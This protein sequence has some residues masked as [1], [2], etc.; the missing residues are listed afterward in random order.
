[1]LDGVSGALAKTLSAGA[2]SALGAGLKEATR[3]LSASLL[4]GSF[5]SDLTP[6]A[7]GG[8][9]AVGT[10]TPFAE[11]GIVATPSYFPLGHGLG[12]MGEAGAEAILP[13]ARGPDGRLGVRSGEA[14]AAPAITVNI[15]A[16]DLDSF[17]R[18]EAQ[19][20]AALARA[21]ARGRR[22]S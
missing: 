17:R 2:S 20:T 12:L 9:L 21:V 15:A 1:M 13:L 11:G 6:F 16:S 3:G 22:A 4:S 18:S 14:P 5:G 7:Q 8:A 10:V 19:V